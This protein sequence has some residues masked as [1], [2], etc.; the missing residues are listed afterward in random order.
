MNVAVTK[1]GNEF[2]S[3]NMGRAAFY[4][5]LFHIVVFVIATVGF[6][7]FVTKTDPVEMA[8]TVDLVDIDDIAQTNQQE[9]PPA[10]KPIYNNTDSMPDLLSPKEPEIAPEIDDVPEPPKEKPEEKPEIVKIEK[11]P[12]PKNKP[13]PPKR[14]KPKI[15]EKKPE[16]KP[17]QNDFNNLLKS[18]VTEEA[19]IK[20]QEVKDNSQSDQISQVADFSK[21]MTSSEL[22]ALNRGV[23]PCW[24]V[25]AGGKNAQDLIVT[26]RVFVNPD[27]SVREV[28]ILDKLRYNTDT[29]FRAA[30]EAARR[31]LLNPRCSTLNLPPEKYE[32]WKVFKY[33]FD[34]S[35]ML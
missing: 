9:P 22:D 20:P 28:K 19:E 6:P 13:R 18:L 1:G 16:E 25:N 17:K 35:N 3:N 31:A 15:E 23:S 11:P 21:Q 2:Y 29:H 14:P 34:P 32:Q 5:A 7:Y 24:N 30:A 33:T 12:K 10:P 27:L 4:S 8:I 26:L